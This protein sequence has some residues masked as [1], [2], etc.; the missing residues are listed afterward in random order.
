MK[1][2]FENTYKIKL[3]KFKKQATFPRG[4]C[5]SKKNVLFMYQLPIFPK[6][7]SSQL[8]KSSA[9]FTI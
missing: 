8:K 2:L 9:L 1:Y 7:V 5:T 3:Y 6:W 4:G